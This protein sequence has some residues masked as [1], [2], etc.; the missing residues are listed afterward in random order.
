MKKDSRPS[1]TVFYQ[2]P[3]HMPL[4]EKIMDLADQHAQ[5]LLYPFQESTGGIISV[6]FI[7]PDDKAL[8]A[9]KKAAVEAAWK[10]GIY[11]H[12]GP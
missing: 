2:I 1:L 10:I 11:I 7:F 6:R 3:E 5:E 8:L 4:E 9:F 12:F